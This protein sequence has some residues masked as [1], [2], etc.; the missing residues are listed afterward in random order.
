MLDSAVKVLLAIRNAAIQQNFTTAAN[1]SKRLL[2]RLNLRPCG[3]KHHC[4]TL[5]MRPE[6]QSWRKFIVLLQILLG[7]RMSAKLTSQ[8]PLEFSLCSRHCAP[9][10]HVPMFVS[11]PEPYI[12]SLL[13]LPRGTSRPSAPWLVMRGA[14]DWIRSG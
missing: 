10:T 4:D 6:F 14:M 2:R 9:S 3:N 11:Q 1:K 8:P 13:A 5:F 12:C 7:I